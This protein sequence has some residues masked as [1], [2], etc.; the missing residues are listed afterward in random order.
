M[1][2]E[3]AGTI[4]PTGPSTLKKKYVCD[5]CGKLESGTST[6]NIVR[7]MK[8]RCK[9]AEEE[10]WKLT[11]KLWEEGRKHSEDRKRA[12]SSTPMEKEIEKKPALK[13]KIYQMIAERNKAEF[14]KYTA[15]KFKGLPEGTVEQWASKAGMWYSV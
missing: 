11:P 9:T 5:Y 7:H 12:K 10:N 13:R 1:C 3:E 4:T 8:F 14:E 6:S 15:G 2:V